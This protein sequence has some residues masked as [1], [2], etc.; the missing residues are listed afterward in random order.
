[1]DSAAIKTFI[2]AGNATFTLESVATGAHFTYKV[3]ASS[4]GSVHFASVLT[5]PDTYTYAGLLGA[6]GLRATQKSKI[7]ASAPSF[8][9]LDWFMRNMGSE[10]VKFRHAGK[11]GKCGRE[12]TTP[13]SL[14]RGIGP[15]C[16]SKMGL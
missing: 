3:K 14:D 9:G 7:G 16:A 8:R 10:Q 5:N 15:E 2:F 12:L 6:G 4:D 1:M 11:C 13:E